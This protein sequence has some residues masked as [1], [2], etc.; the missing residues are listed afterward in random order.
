MPQR[1]ILGYGIHDTITRVPDGNKRPGTKIDSGSGA[2]IDVEPDTF[3]LVRVIG[4]DLPPRHSVGQARENVRFILENEASFPDCQKHWI[5]NRLT[6]AEEEEALRLLLERFSQSYEV[7]SFD[8]QEYEAIGWDFE[9]FTQP[10]LSDAGLGQELGADRYDTA[11]DQLYRYKNCY[12]MNNNGARNAAF[13]AGQRRAKWVL[14][15]DGNCFVTPSA[16]DD[17]ASSVRR[18]RHLRY[19]VVPMSRILDN[20]VLLTGGEVPPPVEEPQIILR[21]DAPDRFDERCRYG[22]RPKVDLLWRLGIPGPWDKWRNNLWDTPFPPLS[23]LAGNFATAGWVARLFS[24]EGHLEGPGKT[25]AKSRAVARQTA[26][27]T[28]IDRIDAEILSRRAPRST[29][30]SIDAQSLDESQGAAEDRVGIAGLLSSLLRGEAIDSGQTTLDGMSVAAQL[31]TIGLGRLVA[32]ENSREPSTGDRL[33]RCL[34]LESNADGGS[35]RHPSAPGEIWVYVDAL[36]M[37]ERSGSVPSLALTRVGEHLDG[38]LDEVYSLE[39]SSPAALRGSIATLVD[40]VTVAHYRERWTEANAILRLLG[41][42]L[43][44]GQFP[45]A[46]GLE[47]SPSAPRNAACELQHWINAA[48]VAEKLG[49]DLW[50][51]VTVRGTGL[52][53]AIERFIGDTSVAE[54]EVTMPLK[55]AFASRYCFGLSRGRKPDDFHAARQVFPAET[56]IRPFWAF[57]FQ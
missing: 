52:N 57:G 40:A 54:L 36:R 50:N 49:I 43:Y 28:Y 25:S 31:F 34:G 55:H 15:W 29:L 44:H 5:L 2:E 19:F 51:A 18:S 33:Q 53:N 12:V 23:D 10:I 17:I 1:H 30:L 32:D 56:G 4:N 47:S 16:W 38:W 14:P 6:V 46:S 39:P 24:G 45:Y 7:V 48:R 37:L 41:E 9:A 26:I 13:R 22:R 35:K 3:C 11:I 27:A 42:R 8:A 21:K 20:A